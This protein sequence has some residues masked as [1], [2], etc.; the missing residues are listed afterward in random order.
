MEKN[1]QMVK[2]WSCGCLQCQHC[3]RKIWDENGCDLS[4][5]HSKPGAVVLTVPGWQVQWPRIA[6]QN[7]CVH[8]SAGERQHT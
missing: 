8:P 7:H 1:L 3:C 4:V 5:K 6:Q 2:T